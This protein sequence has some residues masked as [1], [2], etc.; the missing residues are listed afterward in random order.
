M[1]SVLSASNLHAL[2]PHSR[3]ITFAVRPPSGTNRTLS[4]SSYSSTVKSSLTSSVLST[5][6]PTLTLYDIEQILFEKAG[7]KEGELRSAFKTLDA[8]EN[9]TVTKGEFQRVI[10]TFLLP[11]T[12]KQFDALLSKIPVNRNGTI[13]YLSFLETYSPVSRNV[14]T[15]NTVKRSW[16]SANQNMT[17]NQLEY[18]LK[19]KISANLKNVV[20]SFR[21]FDYNQNGHLQRHELRRIL[22]NYC[23]KMKD[24]E[25]E[26]LWSR[27]C[28]GNRNT[29]DY[30]YLLKN[31][32]INV[33]MNAR[34]MQDSVEQVLNWEATQQELQ[35][36]QMWRPPSST[37][38][39][40]VED[41]IIDDILKAFRKKVCVN[42]RN[43]VKAF[44]AFDVTRDGFISL[45]ALKSV[46]NSF[47]FPLPN[48]TFQELM[49]RVGFEANGKV[50]WKHFL[51]TFQ[52]PT[53]FE[54]SQKTGQCNCANPVTAKEHDFSNDHVLR[55]LQKYMHEAYPSLRKAFL[56]LDDSKSGKVTRKEFRRIIDCTVFRITDGDFKELM[57]ILDPQHTG[58][59]SY[60]QFLQLFEE[61]ESLMGSAH[62]QESSPVKKKPVVLAWHTAEDALCNKITE[63]LKDFQKALMSVDSKGKGVISKNTLRR[64]ILAYCSS[65][66]EEHFNKLCSGC[67]DCSS[68]G[69]H[70]VEFLKNL[71]IYLQPFGDTSNIHTQSTK[72][73]Q[74]SEEMREPDT[75]N[76]RKESVTPNGANFQK[77]PMDV[78]IRYLKESLSRQKIPVGNILLA[79]IKQPDGKMSKT[80][81]RKVL[82]DNKMVMDDA[83][84]NDLAENLG[85]TNEGLSY[86][87]FASLLEDPHDVGPGVPARPASSHC[88]N[89]THVHRTAA[90]EC[91]SK[92][93]EKL[94]RSSKETYSIFRKADSNG[95][96]IVTMHDLRRLLE[97]FVLIITEKEFLHLLEILGLD[98][99]STLSYKE[100][101]ELFQLQGKTKDTFR[102]HSSHSPK[103]KVDDVDLVCEQAHEYLVVKAK[104]RW[105]DLAKNFREIDNKG[106]TI[107]QKKD[108]RNLF[109]RFALP[110]APNEFEKLWSRYDT[111]GKGYLTQEEFLQKLGVDSSSTNPPHS[112]NAVDD[113]STSLMEYDAQKKVLQRELGEQ[114]KRKTEDQDIKMIEQQIN[115]EIEGQ[116]R[117]FLEMVTEDKEYTFD[118][119][120]QPSPSEY[121][122]M[123]SPEK[124]LYKIKEGITSSHDALYKAPTDWHERVEKLVQPKH[125][126]E[127]SMKDI[128][129]RIEEVVT[130]RFCTI[131]QEFLNTDYAKINVISK[132]DFR[133]ICNRNFMF[134]TD[135]QFENLWNVLPVNGYGNLKYHEF[136]KKYSREGIQKIRP[137]SSRNQESFC[138]SA[139][140]AR[141]ATRSSSLQ[142]RPK[143]APCILRYSQTSD[144]VQRPRTAAPGS[145]PLLNCESIEVKL[146]KNLHRIWQEIL[147]MCKEKDTENLGEITVSDFLAIGE[148]FSM[149]LTKEEFD[150]L[151]V[152]YDIKNIGKFSYPDFIRNC[153]LMPKQK[154]NTL[155]QRMKLQ[156]ARIPMSAGLDGPL[157]VEPMLRIQPKIL[158]CWRPMRRSFL[159]F[160]SGTG[161]IS[162][163]DFKQVLRQYSINLSEDEFFH[164]L[165]YYDKDLTL[166]ISYNDFLRSFIR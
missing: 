93:S 19:T 79:F 146:R 9:F 149:D 18:K 151:I 120:L 46:I 157:Y 43:L 11:L 62:L 88:V 52:D 15:A 124:A 108:V 129:T 159:S 78:G 66:S 40:N 162:I 14:S 44:K 39:L 85:F 166:K 75:T 91:L 127:L 95:D 55:K 82:E 74:Q 51:E 49:N 142:R 155:L 65:L 118:Q 119:R 38:E 54:N 8:D 84:F 136:L 42:H 116:D 31:L 121:F 36:Q 33:D 154:E 152:K 77:V 73:L 128:M 45:D 126:S 97:S 72:E 4:R 7:E 35:K 133:D 47:I 106:N 56:V 165:G 25:F 3:G 2:R 156:K 86:L 131:A 122:Q 12:Q 37:A 30:K 58:F 71:G 63:N 164:I 105:Q 48:G 134:L 13:P 100:F 137:S 143:T 70:Y 83:Q 6:D 102:Q 21:L 61:H 109:Y 24:A 89:N 22:E 135:D 139:S 141:S 110:I 99:G 161:H 90:E 140:P 81:F 69:I 111:G 104:S 125:A 1:M 60:H 64:I 101:L 34:P 115:L 16:S 80:D 130:G 20:R 103:S 28:V 67:G 158:Q 92:L 68:D 41:Y 29:I 10:D 112:R 160:D 138:K 123:L 150:Q 53:G 5:P 26:K 153:V 144:I 96:G 132:E 114:E 117:Y 107:V 32:G 94:R 76:G 145:T 23:F 27:Y 98:M 163:E 17:L 147:K 113:N 59:L 148:K 57:I 87:D 50:A